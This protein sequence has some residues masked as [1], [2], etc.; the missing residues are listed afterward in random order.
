[1][2]NLQLALDLVEKAPVGALPRLGKH[3]R[4]DLELTLD[5][6]EKAPVR[7]LRNN[8][9]RIGLYVP[10]LVQPKRARPPY[11]RLQDL[12]IDQLPVHALDLATR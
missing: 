1:M 2:L 6:V 12:G 3:A 4:S 8:P 11:R 7:M 10:C 5:L 9:L